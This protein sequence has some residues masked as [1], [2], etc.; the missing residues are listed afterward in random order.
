MTIHDKTCLPVHRLTDGQIPWN[1]AFNNIKPAESRSRFQHKQRGF[2]LKKTSIKLIAAAF[3]LGLMPPAF[4]KTI[5]K[6]FTESV[7]VERTVV[8]VKKAE[9]LAT[10]RDDA[11][12]TRTVNVSEAFQNWERVRV[13]DKVK[14]TYSIYVR[15]ELR[16][17]T[18]EEKANP[19]VVEVSGGTNEN[20]NSPAASVGDKITV[21]TKVVAVDKD[22]MTA[23]LEGPNGMQLTIQ[24]DNPANAKHVKVGKT[25]IITYQERLFMSLEVM[26]P[27]Q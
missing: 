12:N 10:L 21:V 3:I 7:T 8:A 5:S 1:M 24:G 4:A 6:E 13:G 19:L 11:G 14:A 27:K 18:K 22:N 26:P 15:G 25:V 2:T 9:R 17:P 23:T 16:K 20:P